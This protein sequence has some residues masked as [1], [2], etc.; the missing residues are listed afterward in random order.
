MGSKKAIVIGLGEYLWDMLPD[1]RKAGGAPVNFAFHAGR[2]GMDSYAITA[3]GDDDLG[4][5]LLDVASMHGIKVKAAVVDRPTGTVQV[6]VSNGQ[7]EYMITEDVAWDHIPVTE[8]TL[9][10]AGRCSAICFGSLAQRSEVSR[11]SVAAIVAATPE[12]SLR[13]FDIN[14]RQGYYS[15]SVIAASLSM[16][17]VLKINVDELKVLLPM[18][19]L[20]GLSDDEACRA[21][22]RGYGLK[23]VALTAGAEYS[24]VYAGEMV[25]VIRTPE[26][27]VV[28]T[29]GAGDAFTGSL[30]GSL[31]ADVPLREAHARAVEV[32]A[33]VC[34][35]AGAWV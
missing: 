30:I 17:N 4:R 6:T 26:V 14:L 16:A 8:E 10:L 21:L 11:A 20:D 3:V 12:R 29:V 2:L 7:P 19:G 9:A 1:G 27:D 23:I 32:A 15:K 31:L 35:H 33:E 13:V 5:E 24:S 25:S 34:R 22:M 28:D 18:F